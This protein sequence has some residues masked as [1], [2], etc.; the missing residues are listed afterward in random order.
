MCSYLNVLSH[1]KKFWTYGVVC[2][3]LFCFSYRA[4]NLSN[5]MYTQKIT[6]KSHP[7]KE[8]QTVWNIHKTQEHVWKRTA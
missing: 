5:K 7:C 4:Q 8:S 3:F 1:L 2:W 6:E